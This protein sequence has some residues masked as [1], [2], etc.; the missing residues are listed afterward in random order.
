MDKCL[1]NEVVASNCVLESLDITPCTM[2]ESLERFFSTASSNFVCKEAAVRAFLAAVSAAVVCFSWSSMFSCL[3]LVVFF[4]FF[5]LWGTK[6]FLLEKF[7]NIS[8]K[9]MYKRMA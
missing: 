1:R 9:L 2:E 5:F 8:K 3:P 4:L 7:L 6:N